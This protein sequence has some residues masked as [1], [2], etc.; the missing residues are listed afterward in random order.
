M[1]INSI[2]FLKGLAILA[3]IALHSFTE[4]GPFKLLLLQSVPIFIILMGFNWT[5]SLNR[6]GFE[7]K[8]Y[9]MK[10]TMRFILPLIPIFFITLA[11]LLWFDPPTN[12]ITFA[13]G[14][15][16]YLL[17]FLGQMPVYGPG[18]YYIGVLLQALIAIPILW[19]FSKK[20]MRLMLMSAFGVSAVSEISYF[21]HIFPQDNYIYELLIFRW[22]FAIALGIVLV[23]IVNQRIIPLW[24]KVGIILS[25]AI[26]LTQATFGVMFMTAY[27]GYLNVLTYSFAAGLILGVIFLNLSWKPI[28]LLG[29]ASYHIFLSQM[30]WFILFNFGY[31]LNLIICVCSGVTFYYFNK[32]IANMPL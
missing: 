30:V 8:D 28:N 18:N 10:K 5:M 13:N 24:L 9:I 1:R 11:I 29:Q 25:S 19:W 31:L 6:S 7:V 15:L 20:D 2:D 4:Y 23:D 12:I 21:L 27:F 26:I 16:S 32:K 17:F 22:V 14:G 3:V